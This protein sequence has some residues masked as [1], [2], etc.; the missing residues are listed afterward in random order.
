MRRP[1]LIIKR[2][3]TR[4]WLFTLS[5]SS[6]TAL[7]LSNCRAQFVMRSHKWSTSD[8][9]AR[10]SVTDRVSGSISISVPATDGILTI[11]PSAADWS[12]LSDATGIFTAEFRISDRDDTSYQY[13]DDVVIRVDPPEVSV[14]LV[15]D[16]TRIYV[17]TTGNDTND[18]S[19]VDL[20]VK[21]LA[22][23]RDLA[24]GA[25]SADGVYITILGGE[26][27]LDETL[28]LTTEHSG[29]TAK[30][31]VYESRQGETVVVSGGKALNPTWVSYGS[32]IYYTDT[33]DTFRQ[34]YVDGERAQRAK[35][36]W[37][38]Y[39]KWEPIT[40]GDVTDESGKLIS[41]RLIVAKADIAG[42]TSLVNGEV[43]TLRKFESDILRIAAVEDDVNALD[44]DPALYIALRFKS[45][46][47]DLMKPMYPR[48]YY[49]ASYRLFNSLEFMQNDGDWYLDSVAGRLYYKP[50]SDVDITSLDFTI[51]NLE[52]VVKFEGDA[53]D[54]QVHDIEFKNITFEKTRWELPSVSGYITNQGG[55]VA[56]STV[57]Y[58]YGTKFYFP[59]G[60]ISMQKANNITFTGCE[61]RNFGGSGIN[62]IADC[63]YIEI[64]YCLIHKIAALG[65][66]G[67]DFNDYPYRTRPNDFTS[68]SHLTVYNNKILNTGLDYLACY[69]AYFCYCEDSSIT[70]NTVAYCPYSGIAI[71]HFSYYANYVDKIHRLDISYNKIYDFMEKLGEGGGIYTYLTTGWPP[72]D[73]QYPIDSTISHNYVYRLH[74]PLACIAEPIE[75]VY[76]QIGYQGCLL[77][78]ADATGGW[79]VGDNVFDIEPSVEG[80]ANRFPPTWPSIMTVNARPLNTYDDN[81]DTAVGHSDITAEAGAT[82]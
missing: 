29:T 66:C 32:G 51:P 14:P 49:N 13:T 80:F 27:V 19:T 9:F 6:G 44:A 68:L 56:T 48:A 34:L 15:S 36:D 67:T 74:S 55:G 8:L 82:W 53:V 10:D 18:G 20:A 7:D 52:K 43:Q 71:G 2:D 45:P 24:V 39:L 57:W 65:I 61:V 75:G 64:S 46:D 47:C 72:V 31:V 77:D 5:D 81:Y 38:R 21:T 40:P 11:T 54:N 25:T 28:T 58:D 60:G 70:Y 78:G 76:K 33:T 26:Y 17:S 63:S 12:G 79:T 1:D 30:P 22:R 16:H 69:A 4:P 3:D 23:A 50:G 62:M 37:I 41:G 35:T 59:P 42:Y 73:G